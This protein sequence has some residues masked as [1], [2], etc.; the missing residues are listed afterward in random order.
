MPSA[1]SLEHPTHGWLNH[2]A[3]KNITPAN[4]ETKPKPV[5]K[6]LAKQK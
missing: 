4:L 1:T 2:Y 6:S 3:T 5:V